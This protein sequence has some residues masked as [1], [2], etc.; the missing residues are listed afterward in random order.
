M[1]TFSL[2]RPTHHARVC[3]ATTAPTE[4]VDVTDAVT[5]AVADAGIDTGMVN[6]QTTHTTTAVLVNEAEP[7]LLED[8]RALLARMAPL[9]VAYRHDDLPRRRDVPLDEPRNGHAHC[10]ALLLPTSVC[11]NVVDGRPA[12]GRWQRVFLVEFDGPRERAIS[13]VALG[14]AR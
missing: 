1:D 5:R 3:L 12:L 6:V 13:I 2:V 7:L 14:A 11:L 8:F 9:G 4:F 10:R